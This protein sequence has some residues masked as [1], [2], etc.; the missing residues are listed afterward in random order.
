MLSLIANWM[1][2]TKTT[3]YLLTVYTSLLFL[4][5]QY[6]LDKLIYISLIDFFVYIELYS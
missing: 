6:F 4:A 3:L 1:R 5:G 2:K